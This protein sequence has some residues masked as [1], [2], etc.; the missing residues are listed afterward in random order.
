MLDKL[1]SEVRN[2]VT[3]RETPTHQSIRV[4]YNDTGDIITVFESEGATLTRNQLISGSEVEEVLN[5]CK[6]LKLSTSKEVLDEV[7]RLVKDET[8]E[9]GEKRKE[10]T[11]R[12]VAIRA[13]VAERLNEFK[14]G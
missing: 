1:K 7:E 6:W 5:E 2:K 9:S 10:V 11:A 13:F 8:K 12:N 4:V 14:P 3:V